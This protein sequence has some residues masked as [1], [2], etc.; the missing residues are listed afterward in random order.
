MAER[1]ALVT[2]GA[3]FIGSHLCDALLARG[4]AVRVLDDFSTGREENVDP[5]CEVIRADVSDHDALRRGMDGAE[6]VFHLAARVTIR[7]S[8]DCFEADARTNLMG[9]LAVLGVAGERHVRRL[10]FA[11]SMGVYADAGE[12]Q[13]TTE[14][15]PQ[16]PIS[17][18]GISKLAGEKYVLQ[19]SPRLG[20]EPVALRFFNTYGTRQGY[21][22]YV[23]VI[24]I[25]INKL[26]R[27]EG[28]TIFGD[29]RQCRDFV[30]VSDIVQAN[31]LA[32]ETRAVG[33]V[34][35]VGTGRSTSVL[36]VAA[37]LRGMLRPE[38][39]VRHE[40]AREEELR[41]AVA[42]VGKARRLLGYE[43]RSR[44]EDRIGEVIEYSRSG[45]EGA[46]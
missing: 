7:G 10:V 28:L 20:V 30:H 17:P 24:T 43:P 6:V 26:L 21:T 42:D 29:G 22:P 39:S 16:E 9:T 38:A 36:D 1:T 27:G 23:G 32:M 12:G 40:P 15:H 14:E 44:L 8:V 2:G 31:L 46:R 25:F 45:G 19:L 4:L 37:L 11:S 13:L 35:N 18:Y 3:G 34:F 5:R 41:H 33:E